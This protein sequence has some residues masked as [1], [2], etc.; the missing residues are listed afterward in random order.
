MADESAQRQAVF[1][2]DRADVVAALGADGLHR[3]LSIAALR[4]SR[5]VSVRDL[6]AIGDGRRHPLSE[7]YGSL[8]AAQRDYPRAQSL[9]DEIDWAATQAAIDLVAASGGGTVLS[10]AGTYLCNRSLLFPE[11]REWGERGAEV[12]WLGEGKYATTYHWPVDLGP[13]QAAV[14]CPGRRDPGGMY[15]GVWQDIGLLGPA[16]AAPAPGVMPA[17]MDGWGWGARRRMVRCLASRFRAGLSI[18]GDHSRFEDVICRECFYAVHFAVPSESLYGD[19][20]FEKC[21]FSG[22]AMAAIAVAPEAQMGGCTLISCYV[23][24]SPYAL[25]KEAAPRGRGKDDVLISN[26]VFLNCMFEY[27]GNAWIQDANAPRRAALRKVTFDTC[28]FQ[29]ANESRWARAPRQALWDIHRAEHVVWR[30][31]K[32]PFAT[33]PGDQALL[34]VARAESCEISGHVGHLLYN[35]AQARRPLLHPET[36]QDDSFRGWSLTEPGGWEA[37]FAA[38]AAEGPGVE[39]GQVLEWAPGGRVRMGRPGPVPVAGICLMAAPPGGVTVLA[40]RAGS[41]SVRAPEGGADGWLVKGPGGTAVPGGREGA[42]GWCFYA[43][44]G[45]ATV[46]LG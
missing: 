2:V 42:I 6:G 31:P 35:C 27:V 12:N 44:D 18:V 40:V 45:M 23:G 9:N 5:L 1:R 14:L 29:W 30:Q 46:A 19:L 38:V 28:Y 22:C 39:R 32:E 24:G 43:R 25:L 21:M 33:I 17:A 7:R 37:R 34:K 4:G 15:E 11:C 10:P 36:V 20:L 13:G 8:A 26:S 3:P 16:R 41:I